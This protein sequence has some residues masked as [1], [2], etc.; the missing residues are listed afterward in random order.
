MPHPLHMF[1]GKLAQLGKKSNSVIRSR[2]VTVKNW[3]N[4]LSTNL[5]TYLYPKISEHNFLSN[6]SVGIIKY[7]GNMEVSSC[8]AK[9]WR[10]LRSMLKFMASMF[11]RNYIY[12][13]YFIL[14]VPIYMY[15][16][17]KIWQNYK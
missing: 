13:I 2:S 8:V 5:S 1:Y 15:N 4:V 9:Q 11:L 16:V 17:C 7:K 3:C 6:T 12:S 14:L 10:A